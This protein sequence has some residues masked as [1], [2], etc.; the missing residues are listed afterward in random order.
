MTDVATGWTVNRSVQ[1]KAAVYVNEA[2]TTPAG[3][4]PSRSSGSTLTTARSSSTRTST[5]TASQTRSPSPAPGPATR[6]TA[7]MSSRRTGPTS[8]SSSATCALTPPAELKLLKAIWELDPVF[9]NLLLAQQKLV[10]R[11]RQGAKVLKRL[12]LS[13][14][15]ARPGRTCF[16]TGFDVQ[17]YLKAKMA[18]DQGESFGSVPLPLVEE[19]SDDS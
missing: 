3:R 9:T 19:V 12:A 15:S 5:T 16:P 18:A 4:S 7:A 8:A 17:G 2:S 14:W 1:N 10:R 11:E 6:T 13:S